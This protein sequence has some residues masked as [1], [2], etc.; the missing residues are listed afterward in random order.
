MFKLEVK[1][2]GLLIKVILKLEGVQINMELGDDLKLYF[3]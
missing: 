1:E 2:L 3:G